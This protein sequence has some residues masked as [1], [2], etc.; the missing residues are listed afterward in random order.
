MHSKTTSSDLSFNSDPSF[1]GFRPAFSGHVWRRPVPSRQETDK[2][3]RIDDSWKGRGRK[4]RSRSRKKE[5]A[6]LKQWM[7]QHYSLFVA[8]LI[9]TP[10][11]CENKP[12]VW[13]RQFQIL[14]QLNL[15]P[16]LSSIMWSYSH[17]LNHSVALSSIVSHSLR[18]ANDKNTVGLLGSRKLQYDSCH[19]QAHRAHNK[20]RHS[21]NVHMIL[22]YHPWKISSFWHVGCQKVWYDALL[23][24]AP[25]THSHAEQTSLNEFRLR[26]LHMILHVTQLLQQTVLPQPMTKCATKRLQQYVTLQ[27]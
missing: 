18:V 4:P 5:I 20:I 13:F 2:E 12:H 26:N 9:A 6:E 16:A 21:T 1:P 27:W 14:Q 19:C 3:G 10:L 25:F 15:F 22:T 24:V 17:S 23:E 7:L 11:A 8:V